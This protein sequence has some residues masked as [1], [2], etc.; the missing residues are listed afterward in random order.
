[1]EEESIDEE[2]VA[3][4]EGENN[5]VPPLPITNDDHI[6]Q[7]M[8]VLAVSKASSIVAYIQNQG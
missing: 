3:E 6:E 5:V 2:E 7:L 1:V 4:L 8:D